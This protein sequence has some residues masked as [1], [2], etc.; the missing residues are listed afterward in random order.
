MAFDIES[1]LA[2]PTNAGAPAAAGAPRVLGSFAA[3]GPCMVGALKKVAGSTDGAWERHDG[4]D[5]L[6][7]V[8]RGRATFT[9]CLP[10]GTTEVVEVGPGRALLIPRGTAHSAHIVEDV[11]VFFVTPREGNVEWSDAEAGARVR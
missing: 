8:F 5:E 6:L 11:H 2:A 7:V 3:G 9:I 4:G 1:A 10:D